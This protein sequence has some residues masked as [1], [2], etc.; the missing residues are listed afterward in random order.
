MATRTR[1]WV[2]RKGTRTRAGWARFGQ[3][4]QK[5][6]D[7]GVISSCFAAPPR[8]GSR[9]ALLPHPH[10]PKPG[11]RCRGAFSSRLELSGEAAPPACVHMRAESPPNHIHLDR[12]AF[13]SRHRVLP[14][15]RRPRAPAP[16]SSSPSLRVLSLLQTPRALQPRR[17]RCR[18]WMRRRL[19][20]SRPGVCRS[21]L[22]AWRS[23]ASLSFC[24]RAALRLWARAARSD[25]EALNLV[26]VTAA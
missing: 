10:T 18:A 7:F 17:S 11:C 24:P 22:Y 6:V 26:R 14:V 9:Y 8:P 2:G 4:G 5:G 16:A 3:D 1:V 19:R 20:A 23:H 21:S 12:C 13:H 15:P 25:T